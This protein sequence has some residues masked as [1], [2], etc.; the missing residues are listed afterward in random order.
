MEIGID[1]PFVKLEPATVTDQ[2]IFSTELRHDLPFSGNRNVAYVDLIEPRSEKANTNESNLQLLSSSL[3]LVRI[4]CEPVDIYGDGDC[5]AYASTQTGT[6][7]KTF[8]P[9]PEEDRSSHRSASLSQRETQHLLSKECEPQQSPIVTSSA[10]PTGL[11][12]NV[13]IKTEPVDSAYTHSNQ[14]ESSSSRIQRKFGK[15]FK[16]VASEANHN[17]SEQ[18][19]TL[20]FQSSTRPIVP[21]PSNQQSA[22]FLVRKMSD[23]NLSDQVCKQAFYFCLLQMVFCLINIQYCLEIIFTNK[24]QL[25]LF[26]F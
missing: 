20:D 22:S 26:S 2:D 10:F 8:S 17:D 5:P 16:C 23:C 25:Y 21:A 11:F 7:H 19:Y 6:F 3:H 13:Y 18:N 15:P 14:T 24:C 12:R 1:L 9:C 4:K